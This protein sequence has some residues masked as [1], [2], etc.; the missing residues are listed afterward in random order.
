[1]RCAI[2]SIRAA[3][4]VAIRLVS[5][6]FDTIRIQAQLCE[7]R[8]ESLAAHLINFQSLLRPTEELL[9]IAG[10]RDTLPARP[11]CEGPRHGVRTRAQPACA[12]RGHATFLVV[13]HFAIAIKR[14][15][16]LDIA[17]HAKHRD[18]LAG[19]RH[20]SQFFGQRPRRVGAVEQ[21]NDALGG[22]NF[23]NAE[24]RPHAVNETAPGPR[25]SSRWR[26]AAR[27]RQSPWSR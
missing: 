14:K 17:A 9:D 7:F 12:A 18:G 1:M 11:G 6:H 21:M 13:G 10:L 26:A 4:F 16:E 19:G 8:R 23:G 2:R 27:P 24:E 20:L 22:G 5:G 25:A 15:S 3:Q